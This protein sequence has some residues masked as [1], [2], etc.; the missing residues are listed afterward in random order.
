[1]T[2][3]ADAIGYISRTA[4]GDGIKII[5]I[6]QIKGTDENIRQKHYR[7]YRELYL[8]Y[9]DASPGGTIAQGFASYMREKEG[10]ER[11]LRAG[12]IPTSFFE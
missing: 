9:F 7:L 3:N 8:Y 4:V 11:M 2:N 12:F 6:N 5:S 10:Q 1:M